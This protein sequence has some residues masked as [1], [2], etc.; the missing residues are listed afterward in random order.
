M[1]KQ[2]D[3]IKIAKTVT[4]MKTT[5]MSDPGHRFESVRSTW[6]SSRRIGRMMEPT[7]GD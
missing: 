5:G 6:W 3:S 7:A 4:R 1:R 2:I